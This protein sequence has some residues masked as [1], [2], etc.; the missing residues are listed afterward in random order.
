MKESQNLEFKKSLAERKEILETISAFSN[1]KGGKILVGIEENKDGSVKEVV[2]VKI[3]GKE[4]ENLTNEIKQTTDPII[5]P[6]VEL[7]KMGR[8]EILVIDVKESPIK[9]VVLK[10]GGYKRVGRSNLKLTV[11]EIREMT[12]ESVDYNFTDLICEGAELKDVDEKKINEFVKKAKEERSFNLK[13]GS[14]KEFFKKMHLVSKKGVKY[15]ALLLF[16]TNTQDHLLQSEVRCGRFKGI[17]PLEFEDM[18]VIKGTLIEQVDRIMSFVKRN[19]KMGATFKEGIE[20]KEKWEY[21]LL[22]L[23]EGIVNAV[24]HRD[25][26]LSSNVQ[27]R[28]FDDRLEIWSPGKLPYG[29]T[30]AKL[31]GKHESKP[32]NKEVANAFFMIKLIEQWGTGTN[33]I[34][35]LCHKHNLPEP[36]FEDTG[37]SFVITFKKLT[38]VNER[39][40][41]VNELSDKE[42][43][44]F[45]LM[46]KNKRVVVSEVRNLFSI[47]R[48][49]ANRYLEKLIKK[50][51]LLRKGQGKNTYYVLK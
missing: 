45:N 49:M 42:K 32:R 6:S 48:V 8:R 7:E 2:G 47:S 5:F 36:D 26:A 9:P 50:G 33:R 41:K 39:L 15:S 17:K 35:E 13:Y 51:F 10:E 25:Y 4:I 1:T 21:P 14:K 34:I 22:A 38:K 19:L 18:E 3:K 16:G 12:K 46:K 28:I 27:I 20:R 43:I 11:A 30:A 24:C 44:I 31:K 23:K 29:L 37:T 40:T